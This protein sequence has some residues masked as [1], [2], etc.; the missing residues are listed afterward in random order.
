MAKQIKIFF[1]S[2]KKALRLNLGIQHRGLKHFKIYKND[3]TRMTFD[4]FM[5]WSN[6]CPS[7][8]GNTGRLFHGI[9]KYAG[10]RIMA[11]IFFFFFFCFFFFFFVSYVA[12]YRYHKILKA[13]F[14]KFYWRHFDL[15]SKVNVA[16]KSLLP[17]GI[18]EPEFYS[19][20]VYKFRK[21]YA[22]NDFSTQFR[23][24]ILRYIKIG[25]NINVTRQTA[26]M[27]INP[28][29]VNNFASLISCMPAGRASDSMTAPA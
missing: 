19:N 12:L 7:C 23:K 14:S 6:L 8:Y 21:I 17:Q 9:C 1:S 15:V 27:V 16:L 22:C 5:I 26:C 13:F 24:I 10:E 20:F 18:S 25:Y 2:T 3:E 29:T 4:L 11:H 28:I